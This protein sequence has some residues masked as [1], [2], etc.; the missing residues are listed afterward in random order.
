MSDH[1]SLA[2]LPK[3]ISMNYK[4]IFVEYDSEIRVE[5]LFMEN[6]ED[7]TVG[8]LMSETLRKVTE[9]ARKNNLQRDLSNMVALKTKDKRYAI[10]YWL[11]NND[12]N[13]LLLKDRMVLVPYFSDDRYKVTDQK[14]TIDYFEILKLIGEGGFSKVYMGNFAAVILWGLSRLFR[15]KEKRY[16]AVLCHKSDF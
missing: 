16:G 4:A 5:I 13:I 12:R 14:I 8:W 9:Y 7:L 15:S 3:T 11:S 10:D 1:S 2:K 6:E